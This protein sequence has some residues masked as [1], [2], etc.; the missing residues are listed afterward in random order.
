MLQ[1]SSFIDLTSL[2]Y[3]ILGESSS[4]A[5]LF[6]LLFRSLASKYNSFG[7]DSDTLEHLSTTVRTQWEYAFA[8]QISEQ[9][10][11]MVWLP[12]LVTLLQK[13]E[14]GAWDKKLFVR[15]LVAMQFIS[16][17]LQ[18]PELAFKLKSGEDVNNIQVGTFIFYN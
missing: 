12:S 17:K 6:V 18:D 10:S 16:D 7:Q 14:M 11:C 1:L 13:I 3:R 9:Y 5:S 8:L 15:L 2:L 4:L